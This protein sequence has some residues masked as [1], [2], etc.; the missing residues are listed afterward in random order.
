MRI[1]AAL[2]YAYARAG[3]TA[4]AREILARLSHPTADLYVSPLSSAPIYCALG[5]RDGA[6]ACINRSIAQDDE[7]VA[8]L[9]VDPRL[10]DP[11]F[12]AVLKRLNLH[13]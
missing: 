4:E 7:D 5:D 2:G 11:R 9:G 1:L 3:R 12:E 10:R 13:A 6:F 8:Y